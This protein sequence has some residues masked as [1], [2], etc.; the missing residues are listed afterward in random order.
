MN[1]KAFR[2]RRSRLTAVAGFAL[3]LAAGSPAQT[4]NPAVVSHVA[5]CTALTGAGISDAV[6]AA[7]HITSASLVQPSRQGK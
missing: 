6:G 7:V 1:E 2:R 4:A 3:A 5:D